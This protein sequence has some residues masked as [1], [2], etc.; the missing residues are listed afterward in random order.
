MHEDLTK[1]KHLLIDKEQEI[2]L[3]YFMAIVRKSIKNC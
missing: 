1:E 2:V 3:N